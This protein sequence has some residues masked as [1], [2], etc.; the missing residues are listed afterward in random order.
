[1]TGTGLENLF[2][3]CLAASLSFAFAG[4]LAALGDWLAKK[5]WGDDNE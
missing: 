1:M 2:I 4:A 3:V 5:K